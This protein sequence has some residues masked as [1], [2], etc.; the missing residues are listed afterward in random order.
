M[1]L[2]LVLILTAYPNSCIALSLFL[3][4]FQMKTILRVWSI[5]LRVKTRTNA[6][7]DKSRKVKR[8][9]KLRL[10]CSYYWSVY[11]EATRHKNSILLIRCGN[12]IFFVRVSK[13]DFNK[14]LF[15]SS[16]LHIINRIKCM[17]IWRA[18]RGEGSE[19]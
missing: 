11:K 2:V 8:V 18:V 6:I 17:R 9:F 19:L 1:F 10:W 13:R 5:M 7:K 4:S 15:T 16:H 3:Y 12:T 14:S